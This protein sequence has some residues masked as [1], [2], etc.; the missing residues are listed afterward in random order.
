LQ[1]AVQV[2]SERGYDRVTVAAVVADARVSRRTFYELFDSSEDCLLAVCE[3]HLA[4]MASVLAPVYEGR[5]AWCERLRSAVTRALEF[6]EAEREEGALT[7]AFLLG[8]G[9]KSPRRRA[10][11]LGALSAVLEDGRPEA[12]P[13][14]VPSPLAAELLLAGVLGAL[15]ARMARRQ[16]PLVALVNP[17]MSMLVL[18]YLGGD[19]AASELKRARPKRRETPP[20][21]AVDPLRELRIRLTYRTARVLAAIAETPGLSNAEVSAAADVT[22]QGQISKLLARLAG[23]GVI[24]NTGTGQTNGAANAWRLTR[25][26][27]DVEAAIG[28]HSAPGR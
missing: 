12:P 23:L 5:G 20:R 3:E 27:N 6:L 15:H 9:P 10:R 26:G 19:A 7:V 14:V 2:S 13:G 28:R 25:K 18:P 16:E 22:D 24:E 17:L 8:A 4:E 21:T 1:A 11:A